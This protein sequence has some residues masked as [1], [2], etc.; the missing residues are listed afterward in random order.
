MILC[1]LHIFFDDVPVFIDL[2][3]Y[4]LI[5]ID[6]LYILDIGTLSYM[7]FPKIFLL[8]H[9]LYFNYLKRAFHR[10]EVLNVTEVQLTISSF[11]DHDLVLYLK[12]HPK[13]NGDSQVTHENQ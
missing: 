12:D 3:S 9:G 7:Y 4:C 6:S 13:S 11:M 10:A 2:F 5:F 8:Y 1:H